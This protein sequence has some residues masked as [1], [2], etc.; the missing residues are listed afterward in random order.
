M[1]FHLLP[2]ATMGGCSL[3]SFRQCLTGQQSG[4]RRPFRGVP[5]LNVP[6]NESDQVHMPSVANPQAGPGTMSAKLTLVNHFA[7]RRRV[8]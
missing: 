4:V 8:K 3:R 5:F 2:S 7:K 1:A 6:S